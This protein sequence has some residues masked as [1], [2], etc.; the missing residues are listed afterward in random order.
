MIDEALVGTLRGG[1]VSPKPVES[2]F[3]LHEENR[4][5]FVS[6]GRLLDVRFVAE[7]AQH[8]VERA[9]FDTHASLHSPGG[10][11]DLLH[12]QAL[13]RSGWGPTLQEVVE[14]P[15]IVV[16]RLILKQHLFTAEPMT[17]GVACGSLFALR[18]LGTGAVDRVAAVGRDL[19]YGCHERCPLT[20][21]VGRPSVSATGAKSAILLSDQEDN[22][23]RMGVNG[24]L[25]KAQRRKEELWEVKRRAYLRAPRF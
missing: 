10:L 6:M 11:R 22:F 3:V 24:S 20:C 16:R 8:E 25:V 17:K 19:F 9:A 7:A 13:L 2:D 18:R 1:H 14:E 12:Q 4:D 15:V 21:D 5:A 23:C